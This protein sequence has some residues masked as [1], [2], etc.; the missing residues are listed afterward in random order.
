MVFDEVKNF[1]NGEFKSGSSNKNHS[2]IS[3]LDGSQL[4]TFS[5]STNEDLNEIIIYAQKAQK[6]WQKLTLKERAQVFYKY[7]SLIHI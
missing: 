7:L 2:V 5:E 4:S 1:I 6:A 3:P